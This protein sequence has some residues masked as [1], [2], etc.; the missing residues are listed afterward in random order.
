MADSGSR[1]ET[2]G[3]GLVTVILALVFL[4][5]WP[6]PFRHQYAVRPMGIV[7]I[8]RITGEAKLLRNGKYERILNITDTKLE[9]TAK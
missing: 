6:G 1:V 3:I 9:T 2:G 4:F 5:Y 8:D 7:K